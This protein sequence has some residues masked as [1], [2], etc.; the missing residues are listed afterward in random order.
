MNE[1][2]AI[3]FL[4]HFFFTPKVCVRVY[5]AKEVYDTQLAELQKFKIAQAGPAHVVGLGK[6][7]E[8]AGFSSCWTIAFLNPTPTVLVCVNKEVYDTQLAKLQKQKIE[9]VQ[10]GLSYLVSTRL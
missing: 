1:L 7:I 8:L 2:W 3:A 9:I 6:G 4:N 5:T 10:N